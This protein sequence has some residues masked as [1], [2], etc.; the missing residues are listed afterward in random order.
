MQNA[1][2]TNNNEKFIT[3][4]GEV[5]ATDAGTYN[6]TYSL[7]N[8]TNTTWNDDTVEAVTGDWTINKIDKETVQL[9]TSVKIGA[10]K[11]FD[12]SN[13]VEK[14]GTLGE[15]SA[16]GDTE[17]LETKVLEGTKLQ[18]KA[19]TNADATKQ[20]VVTIPVTGAKNYNDYEIRVT[21]TVTEKQT[22]DDFTANNVTATYG[23]TGVIIKSENG[24]GDITYA[25]TDGA[26]IIDVAADGKIEI[27]KAGTATV[28]VKASGDN[29]YAEATKTITVTVAKK[30]LTITIGS[31]KVYLNNTVPTP[32]KYT[33]TGFVG[34]DNFVTEPTL[35]YETTPDTS[36]RG[37]VAIKGKDA[38]AGDNYTIKYID[39]MLTIAKKS[40]GS[41]GGGSSV[42]TYAVTVS[43][44][45]NGKVTLDKTSAA[46][47]SVVT[48]TTKANDGYALGIIKATD[49][50]GK[51]IKLTDKGDGKYTFTMPASKV[52]VKAAFKQ[53]AS[54]PDQPAEETK[55]VVVMQI[56]SKTMFVN[57]KAYEKDVA[58]VIMNDRTLV[59]I[60]FITES[61]GG[62]VAWNEKEKEVVLTI[63]GKEIKMTIGKVLEKYSVAPVILNDRTYMPVRFVADELGATTTWDAVSKM[64]TVTKI[65]K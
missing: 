57:G 53:N 6:V 16:T 27:K 40:S 1:T 25:V 2:E 59:P 49:K 43:S 3:R 36:V 17:L 63:D 4:E 14:D 31:E 7:K 48:I 13:A 52:E 46:K 32:T 55:T 38:D 24:V 15:A 22:Q 41:S 33:V 30:E 35:Y 65:E 11:K 29:D 21:V 51:E 61:L 34:E 58:P 47:G 10:T 45:D 9:S 50:D 19:A 12:L 20:V 8:T 26:D 54:K 60:R 37:S 44:A 5:S 18:I 23:D 64:V 28:E 39:G 62:K 56:G 42:T